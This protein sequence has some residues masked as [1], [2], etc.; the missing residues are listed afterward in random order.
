MRNYNGVLL[1]FVWPA[2]GLSPWRSWG[3]GSLFCGGFFL[4]RPGAI[5]TMSL[6]VAHLVVLTP[7][8]A[9]LLSRD[10]VW[11]CTTNKLPLDELTCRDNITITIRERLHKNHSTQSGNVLLEFWLYFEISSQNPIFRIVEPFIDIHAYRTL[12]NSQRSSHTQRRV[13]VDLNKKC[14]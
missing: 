10:A 4:K 1:E 7:T 13:S 5:E 14:S 2:L 3:G 6:C 12:A 9:I 11:N 8:Q